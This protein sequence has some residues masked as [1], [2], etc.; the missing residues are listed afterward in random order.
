MT[1]ILFNSSDICDID[2]IIYCVLISS[3]GPQVYQYAFVGTHM[4]YNLLENTCMHVGMFQCNKE[5]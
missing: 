2:S 5:G 4:T 3:Q 1:F